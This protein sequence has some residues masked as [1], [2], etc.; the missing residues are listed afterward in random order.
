MGEGNPTSQV[1]RSERKAP[2]RA[3]GAAGEQRDSPW[4][5]CREEALVG[6]GAGPDGGQRVWG[7]LG[8]E[9]CAGTRRLPVP[10]PFLGVP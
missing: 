7:G 3:V 6:K 2:R 4:S 5:L 1:G 9:Q 10:R 8:Q